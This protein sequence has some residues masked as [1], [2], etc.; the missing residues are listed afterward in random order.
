MYVADSAAM[1]ACQSA[2]FIPKITQQAVQVQTLLALVESGRGAA[3]VP[4]V[5][6]R[7]ASD[8]T[9]YR[10]LTDSPEGG[11]VGLALTY[12]A[13]AKSAAEARFRALAQRICAI[14]V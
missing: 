7:Y 4:S 1:L 11:H 14:P 6:Q 9:L 8:N 13:Q 12:L 3:L 10:P 5:M 2:G